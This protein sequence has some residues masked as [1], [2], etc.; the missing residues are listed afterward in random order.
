MRRGSS[1]ILL[2]FGVLAIGIMVSMIGRQWTMSTGGMAPRTA[3][4]RSW[5]AVCLTN[6]AAIS[7]AMQIYAIQNEPMKSL[8]LGKLFPGGLPL[9][10]GCPCSYSMEISGKVTCKAHH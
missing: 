6:K 8:E 7:Q 4:D 10:Q 1:I 9:P 3:I 5:E 2:L